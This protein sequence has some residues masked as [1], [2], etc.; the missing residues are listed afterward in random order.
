[1]EVKTLVLTGFGLNTDWEMQNAFSLAGAVSHRIHF[2]EVL[3]KK[4]LEQYH[5]LAIPGGF[6]F[7]D[8]IAGG[9]VFGNKLKF[10]LKTQLSDFLDEGKLLLGV[11]NGFQ[12]LSKAGILPSTKSFAQTTALTFNDSGH[13]EDRWVCLQSEKTNCVWTKGIQTLFLPVRHGEGKFYARA[14]T[15]KHLNENKQ[16]VFRYS[17]PLKPKAKQAGYPS[18]PNGSLENIAGICDETGRVF[19]LMPHPEAFSFT[20]NHPRWTREKIE[21]AEGLK[22]FQNAVDYAKRKLV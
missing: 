6:S 21:K 5:I 13:F 15:L 3:S 11:C 20:F 17:N 18:N 10:K 16:I 8:D 19:A 12:I 14:E 7:A 1:M 9:R 22:I 4:L 2:N